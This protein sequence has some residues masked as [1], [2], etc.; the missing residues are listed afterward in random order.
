MSLN[1]GPNATPQTSRNSDKYNRDDFKIPR[2]SDAQEEQVDCFKR[3]G[4]HFIHL[5]V[6]SILP[7]MSELRIIARKTS[8]AVIAIS[9]NSV[10]DNEIS[11]DGYTVLRKD[12]NRN[13]G[14]VCVY[15]KHNIAFN[16]RLDL[17]ND[18]IE[19]LWFELLLPK[20][21][22]VGVCYRPQTNLVFLSQFEET[23]SKI[24]DLIARSWSLVILTS[25][26]SCL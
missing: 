26:T 8:A 13:G 18:M 19:A 17:H 22:I 2:P 14:G 11:I 21:I 7:K 23:V 24:I 3:R 1:P 16:Q 10:T 20:P 6:R 12:R 15:I 25:I 9:D 5:N 4:L